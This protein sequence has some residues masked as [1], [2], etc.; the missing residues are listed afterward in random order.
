MSNSVNQTQP[1]QE[2]H[3][4]LGAQVGIA[5]NLLFAKGGRTRRLTDIAYY[6]PRPVFYAP[7]YQILPPAQAAQLP[8]PATTA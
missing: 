8:A 5:R 1:T 2:R 3:I 6:A 7:Q 4:D